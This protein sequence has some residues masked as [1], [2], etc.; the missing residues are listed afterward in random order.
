MIYRDGA[1]KASQTEPYTTYPPQGST[2]PEDLWK[3]LQAYEDKTG[4][5]LL[6]IAHN[7]NL[8]NGWMF[9]TEVNPVT[10]QPFTR[11]YAQT[12]ARWEPLY[13]ATQVKGDGETHP[14][15]S[16]NDEMVRASS[17]GTRATST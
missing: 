10:K 7:G 2:T 16:P 8:S 12:R 1:D 11:E 13:E 3:V 5:Q 15:I 14:L 4:G 17:S 9:P 6:A